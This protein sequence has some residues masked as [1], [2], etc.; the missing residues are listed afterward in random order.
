ME[1][2]FNPTFVWP[3]SGQE[4]L[5]ELPERPFSV[6]LMPALHKCGIFGQ[7]EDKSLLKKKLQ[8]VHEFPKDKDL[9]Y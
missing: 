2:T 6:H 3:G 8:T 7:K 5:L 9:F 1:S 4:I